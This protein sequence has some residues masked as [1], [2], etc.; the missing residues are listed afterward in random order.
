MNY[1]NLGRAG[2]MVSPLCLGTMM[3][4]GRTDRDEAMRIA[5][6][7]K[8]AGINFLDTANVYNQGRAEEVVREILDETGSDWIV[9]TKVYNAMGNDPNDRGLSRHHVIEA[10]EASLKRLARDHIDLYYLHKED[11]S[12][13]LDETIRAIGDLLRA[14]KVRYWGISNFRAWRIA[15]IFRLC[16]SLGIEGPVASQPLYNC[17]NRMAEAEVLPCCAHYGVGVVPYSPLAR[18]VLT[19]KYKDLSQPD[20]DSRAGH[21]DKRMMETEWRPESI[22]LA[23]KLGGHAENQKTTLIGFSIAW[24]LNNRLVTSPIVGPR[25]TTQME[26]YLEGIRYAFA[27]EDEAIVNE[28]VSP[29]HAST[30]GY[31]DPAYPIEGRLPKVF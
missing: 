26:S 9:A 7:A 27:P 28:L 31:V 12:T 29:G 23:Q 6:T 16:E 25:T 2:L 19:G 15:E 3:F 1:R 22:D 30:H 17:L 14:G 8:A 21:G 20:R 4:G 5:A 13:P 11:H 18:G 24:L 10:C